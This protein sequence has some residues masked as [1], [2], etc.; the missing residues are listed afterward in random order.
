MPAAVLDRA[1]QTL[2]R[3]QVVASEGSQPL[4]EWAVL[5][6]RPL[7][8]LLEILTDPSPWARE[9]RHVTPFAGVLSTEE[10][11]EVFRAFAAAERDAERG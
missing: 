5:L 3:M 4:R 2:A 6:D 1:R 10:R 9:L 7:P 11:A 8:A